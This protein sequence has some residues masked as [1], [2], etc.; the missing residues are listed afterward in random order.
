MN[1]GANVGINVLYSGTVGAAVESAFLGV[2]AIAVS[3]HIGDRTKTRFDRAAAIARSVIDRILAHREG[4]LD[5][6]A[7][8]NVNIPRTESDDLT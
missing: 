1:V 3:L 8:I 5:A 4:R 7:V 6:H 2:P